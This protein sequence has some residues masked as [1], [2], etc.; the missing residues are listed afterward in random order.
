MLVGSGGDAARLFGCEPAEME[1]VTALPIDGL[2]RL[3]VDVGHG[4]GVVTVPE[5][6]DPASLAAALVGDTRAI[7][8]DAG[9]DARA[10]DRPSRVE[11]MVAA[12][13]TALLVTRC[14]Y[15]ALRAAH[16][17]R[18]HVDGV[19]V[20]TEP[21][22]SLDAGDV[23]EAL[24]RPV[25]AEVALDPAVAR[26]VDAGVFAARAPRSLLRPLARLW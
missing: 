11:A 13:A 20:V 17:A 2:Q 15:L 6:L 1:P 7:V 16:G 8:V 3:E 22:R 23:G 26:A 5:A 18:G 14:C 19:V 25:V 9:L 21:G 24:G 12:G 4:V 10:A